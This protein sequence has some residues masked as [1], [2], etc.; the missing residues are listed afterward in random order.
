MAN[1]TVE[2]RTARLG[3]FFFIVYALFYAIFVY[4]S[5]FH[6]DVMSYH[7]GLQVNVAVWYGFTLI[8][9]PLLLAILY[10]RMCKRRNE[11]PGEPNL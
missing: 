7:G 5:A 1:G 9:S 11:K 8:I 2:Q 4:L 3:M 6:L 10:A